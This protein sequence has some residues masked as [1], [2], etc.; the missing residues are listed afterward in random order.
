VH[1]RALTH[2]V[3]LL[4]LHRLDPARY[5]V[6]LESSALGAHGRWDM[7][8]A[9]DGEGFALHRDGTTRDLHGASLDGGFLDVLDAHHRARRVLRDAPAGGMPF[10]GGWAL[11]LGYELA[12]QVEPVLRLPPAAGGL[13]VAVA[14]RCRAALLR[15]RGSGACTLVAEP[16]AVEWLARI[17]ADIQ[18]TR[19]MPTLPSW[20]PPSGIE[21]DPPERYLAGV[22][23]VLDYLV[24]G[25]VFQVNL[26]R[27]WRARFDDA[28]EPAALFQRLR[29]N[30]PAPFAGIFRTPDGSVVSASPERLVSVQGRVVETRPI[31]GTRPRTEGDDDAARIRELVGHPKERAEHV[32]LIDLE[33]NDLG[34]VCEAG[35]V[36]VDELMTVESYAHVHHIVSNVRGTLK[37][38]ATPGQV[39]AAVFPGGTIT[40]CPKV[41]CMQ[42]IA[43]LEEVGRGA[44][45]GA[46]GWLNRDGDMDLNIL[47]RSAEVEG[48]ALRFR[49]GAGIV[50]DSDP[51]RELDETRA[52]A[53]GMLRAL[54]V[55]G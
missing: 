34:R 11:L 14:L 17:D 37:A 47:I 10:R 26:S 15:D 4:D 29:G 23:R 32:M 36:L 27:G 52:K 51:Q 3:D 8:L 35:S 9:H 25:D 7:L 30:N 43:E 22:G 21:E 45:T 1:V 42:V 13:P 24:A 12:A 6:L 46:M 2:G 38:D 20:S 48:D 54:G 31:A 5:P 40:G 50:V 53:R 18:R 33:R 49:T 55:A 39:I 41:R 19:A 16:D 28:L 44:Y